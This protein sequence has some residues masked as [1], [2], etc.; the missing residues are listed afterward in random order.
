VLSSHTPYAFMA[1]CL[2][3][4]RGKF[5][6]YL[7]FYVTKCEYTIFYLRCEFL[8]V[9]KINCVLLDCDAVRSCVGSPVFSEE[10]IAS[11]T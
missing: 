10:C 6:F 8:S 9:L 3:N 5:R 11:R 7:Y 4:T 2:V 1:W